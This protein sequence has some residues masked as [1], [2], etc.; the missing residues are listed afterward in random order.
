MSRRFGWALRGSSA[1]NPSWSKAFQ[2]S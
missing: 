1:G 2:A